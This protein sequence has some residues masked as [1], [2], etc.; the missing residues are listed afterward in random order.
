[1]ILP[2]IASFLLSFILF[3]SIICPPPVKKTT[4]TTSPTISTTTV[5]S[6]TDTYLDDSVS[7]LK[8]YSRKFIFLCYF[9]LVDN[10]FI[11]KLSRITLSKRPKPALKNRWS[12]KT[13][14][15]ST[16]KTATDQLTNV[17]NVSYKILTLSSLLPG[18]NSGSNLTLRTCID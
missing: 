5:F 18:S 7:G 14:K 12:Q 9:I 17:L 1:M 2:K 3:N 6:A 4:K 13:Y 8:K 11:L 10:F 15:I 16:S